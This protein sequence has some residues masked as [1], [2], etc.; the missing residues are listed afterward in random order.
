MSRSVWRRSAL[1]AVLAVAVLGGTGLSASATTTHAARP[2]V[3]MNVTLSVYTCCG[4]LQ[5]FNDTD[6]THLF[7]IHNLYAKIWARLYRSE[8]RRVGK[9]CR[10]R[11]SPYH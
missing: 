4:S 2:H 7:S 10:S 1:A 11:W 5:G 8:E 9:E 3:D 6:P